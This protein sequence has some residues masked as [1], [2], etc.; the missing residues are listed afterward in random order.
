ME[1]LEL[2]NRECVVGANLIIGESS[3]VTQVLGHTEGGEEDIGGEVDEMFNVSYAILHLRIQSWLL[4]QSLILAKL[5][6]IDRINI[7]GNN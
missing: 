3:Q 1:E 5:R 4:R 7:R 2:A 6:Q